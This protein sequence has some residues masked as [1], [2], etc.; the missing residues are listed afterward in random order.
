[1]MNYRDRS[2]VPDDNEADN[3]SVPAIYIYT[4]LSRYFLPFLVPLIIRLRRRH[5]AGK[6]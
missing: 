1:M 6:Y 2:L 4:L 3:K 5:R